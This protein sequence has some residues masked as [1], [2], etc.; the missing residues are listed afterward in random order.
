V[1]PNALGQYLGDRDRTKANRVLQAMREMKKIDIAALEA[2][3][4]G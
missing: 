2:A 1:I 4:A 3:Y